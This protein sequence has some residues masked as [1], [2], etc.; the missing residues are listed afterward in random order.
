MVAKLRVKII[1][2]QIIIN[3]RSRL[4]LRQRNSLATASGVIDLGRTERSALGGAAHTRAIRTFHT[5]AADISKMSTNCAGCGNYIR[6]LYYM[7]CSQCTKSFDLLCV[8]ISKAVY[9][10]YAAKQNSTW[11]CPSCMSSRPRGDNTS[12]P[13]RGLL[14]AHLNDTYTKT[15]DNVNAIRGGKPRTTKPKAGEDKPQ[16]VDLLELLTELRQLRQEVTDV[17]Q[18]NTE[19]KHQVSSISETLT[20]TLKEH[21]Q[22]LR[23][24]ELEISS[25]KNTV[26]HLHQQLATQQ[27]VGL[28]KALEI[29]GV[30]ETNGENLSHILITASKK[31]GVELSES[32]I[33]EVAR[34]G[35][36]SPKT[37]KNHSQNQTPRPI[38]AKLT[39]KL[40]RDELI[41]SAKSRR[42]TS[43]HLVD[44]QITPVFFN[45]RL[46]K[47]NR[48]LFRDARVRTKEYE[49]RYCWVRNGGVYVRKADSK[50]ATR[51]FDVLDL[52][53]K[54]GPAKHPEENN[55]HAKAESTC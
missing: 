33:D 17:K 45:E 39:R 54:V 11:I 36:K 15:S 53:Q 1:Q 50:P 25:L 19:I 7:E 24:A 29:S 12:T 44:G 8:N 47:E 22:Q 55:E 43:E 48:Q 28:R 16:N 23:N 49:F 34:V 46:T 42:L 51:I 20:Q 30:A 10:E 31:I 3:G 14:S 6:D 2:K 5:G 41:K 38:V 13:A 35:P 26:D 52:D 37:A 21:S 4:C 32:D 9:D 27:Q 40:K 18:Q